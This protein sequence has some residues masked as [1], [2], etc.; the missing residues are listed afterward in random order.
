MEEKDILSYCGLY[1]N[2]CPKFIK[3]KCPGCLENYHATWCKTR[4]CCINNN[5]STCAQCSQDLV[6]CKKL[7]NFISKIFSFI[8]KIDRIAALKKIKN[9]GEENFIKEMKKQKS[10]TIKKTK[11]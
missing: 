4:K 6:A 11:I 1:C 3:E 10:I 9:E 5:F 7:N 8:F 2:Q